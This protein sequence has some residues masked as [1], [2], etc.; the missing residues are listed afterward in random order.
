LNYRLMTQFTSFVAV[1]EMTITDGGE[2]RKIEV[3]V[4]MPEGVSHEGVFGKEEDQPIKLN[5]AAA[6]KVMQYAN[7]P[8]PSGQPMPQTETVRVTP[9][10]RETRKGKAASGSGI[11]TGNGSG[12]GSGVGP[13]QGYNGGGGDAER[14]KTQQQLPGKLHPS[15]AAIVE[16]LK[17]KSAEPVADEAKFVRKGKA[18]IQVWLSDKSPETLAKLKQLGFEVVLDPRSA[19][20]V[21][22]RVPIEKLA[23]LAELS[24]V[25]YIAPQT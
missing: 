3:P 5:N 23:A 9:S 19:K 21:I 14:P 16:R 2:P 25:R 15:I 13:G 1:E 12:R 10:P 20:M 4:E 6:G 24:V 22:G 11:G 17:N 18:E 8:A 7:V